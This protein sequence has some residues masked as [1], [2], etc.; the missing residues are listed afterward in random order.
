MPGRDAAGCDVHLLPSLAAPEEL[1]R[2]TAIVIDVLRATTTIITALAAGAEDVIVCLE[3]A[4][5]VEIASRFSS[6]MAVTGGERGGLKIAGFDL[7]N[8]PSEYTPS[9]VRHKSVVF[10]TTN[11]TRALARCAAAQRVLLAGFVNM[12]A[13]ADRIA[14]ND[15][16]Q[17]VCAGTDG[18]VTLEDVLL[19][20]WLAQDWSHRRDPPRALGDAAQLAAALARECPDLPRHGDATRRSADAAPCAPPSVVDALRRSRGG[21][22]LV[23]LGMESDLVLAAHVDCTAIVP[24]LLCDGQRLRVVTARGD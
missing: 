9:S 4:E 19:A 14:D 17:L 20:G 1:E 3:P 12:S 21:R 23:E 5:A 13:V 8:S 16:V 6:G 24:E 22:N 10:T 2:A 18:E 15:R 7:G 11:G